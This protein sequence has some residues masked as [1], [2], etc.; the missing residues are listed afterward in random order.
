MNVFGFQNGCFSHL[1]K[2]EHDSDVLLEDD[3]EYLIHWVAKDDQH[4]AN[5][6]GYVLSIDADCA[7]VSY[8][9]K[10]IYLMQTGCTWETKQHL[11]HKVLEFIALGK[12]S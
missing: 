7:R 12:R 6:A 5:L 2:V 3:G 4:N 10:V 9:D 11:I 8:Q 1:S